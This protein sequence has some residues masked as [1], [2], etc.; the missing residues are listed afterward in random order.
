MIDIEC[1]IEDL[2]CVL[3][4]E[5]VIPVPAG[6]FTEP[7]TAGHGARGSRDTSLSYQLRPFVLCSSLSFDDRNKK[8]A[9]EELQG[10][11]WNR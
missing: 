9:L 4:V 7:L 6:T 10:L 11:F 2:G 1:L 5:G 8:A 3:H